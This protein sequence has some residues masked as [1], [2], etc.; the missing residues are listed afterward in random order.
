MRVLL[1]DF[2]DS[3]FVIRVVKDSKRK[4]VSEKRV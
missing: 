3:C 4:E 1:I 2:G